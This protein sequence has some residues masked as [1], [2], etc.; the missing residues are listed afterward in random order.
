MFPKDKKKL[1]LK[2]ELNKKMKLWN[3]KISK[4]KKKMSNLMWKKKKRNRKNNKNNKIMKMHCLLKICFQKKI[5]VQFNAWK[6]TKKKKN[7]KPKNQLKKL[8]KANCKSDM[9]DFKSF[10]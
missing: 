10:L 5:A 6:V 7:K 3:K 8:R 2:K 4:M 1:M 9:L